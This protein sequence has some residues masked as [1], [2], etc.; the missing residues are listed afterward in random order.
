MNDDVGG[1]LAGDT[2][3]IVLQKMGEPQAIIGE[4]FGVDPSFLQE[5]KSGREVAV[6][7]NN[8]SLFEVERL[9]L[10]DQFFQVILYPLISG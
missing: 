8:L 6:V 3:G 9:S 5:K 4:P 10:G 1:C 2:I 7:K